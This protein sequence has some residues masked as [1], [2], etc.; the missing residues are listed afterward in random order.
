MKL[1]VLSK[2]FGSPKPEHYLAVDL[3]TDVVK[4]AIFR[5]PSD[6]SNSP[7]I[8]GSS[9]QKHGLTSM[10]G[11]E[12]D[13]LDAVLET[14]DLSLEE[15]RLQ[16]GLLPK[17]VI[18][19]LS[20]SVIKNIGITVRVKRTHPEEMVTSEEFELLSEKIEKQT[21]EKAKDS[22]QEL[23]YLSDEL[24]HIGTYFTGYAIDGT[25]VDTPLDIS[26]ETLQTQVLHSFTKSQILEQVNRLVGQLGLQLVALVDTTISVSSRYL[27]DYDQGIVIDLG[28]QV[29][30]VVVFNQRKI[31]GNASFNL[32]SRHFT[33]AIQEVMKINF[34]QAE[35]LKINFAEG[36]LDVQ[37]SQAVRS[38]VKPI[39]DWWVRGLAAALSRFDLPVFPSQVLLF[40]QN[41]VMEEIKSALVA[42]PWNRVLPFN[43]FPK[44]E[45]IG[46]GELALKAL[47]ETQL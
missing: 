7:Q 13:D 11:A 39:L 1:P 30:E 42:H 22:L 27:E 35:K 16:A 18:L 31:I 23:G 20:G 5:P 45:V 43:E 14:I 21:V 41:V 24:E 33:E 40:G 4:T 12:I 36:H 26:G 29:T 6:L 47:I 3:G 2:I 19:G 25:K 8:I 10:I 37:R 32:G 46:D 38:A 28:G 44:M 9:S 15:A 17:S 34:D